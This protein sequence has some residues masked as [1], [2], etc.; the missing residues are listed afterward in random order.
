MCHFQKSRGNHV[1]LCRL[2]PLTLNEAEIKGF[3]LPA[4]DVG[5]GCEVVGKKG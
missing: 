4:Q 5:F 3:V 2:F 1:S